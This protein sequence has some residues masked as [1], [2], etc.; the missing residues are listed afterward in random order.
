MKILV[1]G[2][3]GFLGSAIVRQLRERGD[4]CVGLGRRTYPHLASLDVEVIQGDI[5]DRSTVAAACR[6]VDA[7]IHTAAIAGVWGPWDPYY[8]INTVGTQ[9]V[10]DGCRGAGVGVLVYCSSPSVT[11]DGGDQS[12]SDESL[13]YPERWLCAYPQTKALAEQAVLGEHRPGRFHTAALR[14]HLIWGEHDPHLFPRLLNRA[15]QGRLVRVGDGTNRIDTIHVENAAAAHLHALDALVAG[16]AA[17]GRPYFISQDEPVNC[18]QWIGTVLRLAGLEP[19]R[20]SIGFRKAY[21][22][23]ALLEML[24]RTG[25]VRREPPMTR[26]L[27]AQLAK[28]HYFD[29]SAAKSL[30]NYRPVVSMD[31]GLERLARAWARSAGRAE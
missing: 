17:G 11:F 2:Y 15:R 27:A 21:A 13:P 20:R 24:F 30:L 7:V 31:E 23:G 8:E 25:R 26:F 19:P 16:D 4:R 29:I 6:G 5:R 18:W 9:N 28:D 10:I 22:A 14:P 12:G 1:T 3:G